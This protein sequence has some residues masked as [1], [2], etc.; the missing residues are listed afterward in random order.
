MGLHRDY[1]YGFF[2]EVEYLI[3]DGDP[4][5]NNPMFVDSHNAPSPN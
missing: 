3:V 1:F 5:Q 4:R 2:Y